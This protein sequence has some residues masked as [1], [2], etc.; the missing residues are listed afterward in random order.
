MLARELVFP[1]PPDVG[2][3]ARLG[4][5]GHRVVTPFVVQDGHVM[6]PEA[7]D[8]SPRL[9]WLIQQPR[10]VGRTSDGETVYT[11]T[12][13]ATVDS[14][15]VATAE[16][17]STE[18]AGADSG[19]LGN[20]FMTP[21]EMTPAAVARTSNSARKT[22]ARSRPPAE[23]ED[24][25][26][27]L[28]TLEHGLALD[29]AAKLAKMKSGKTL[30][31]QRA[32]FE[33][34]L[35][36]ARDQVRAALRA[37]RAAAA[38]KEQSR[39]RV[40]ELKREIAERG[41]MTDPEIRAIVNDATKKPKDKLP[42]LRDKLMAKVLKAE[43]QAAHPDNE[44]VDGVKIYEKLAETSIA[45]WKN[46]HPGQKTDGLTERDDGLYMQ[47]GEI[48][49]MVIER[50][51][52]GVRSKI[53]AREEIKTGIVDTDA[54]ARGQ[55]DAQGT[56]FTRGASGETTVRLELRGRDISNEIDLASDASASKST[57]GPAGKAFDNSLG[58]TATDLEG[59]CRD[60][61]SNVA[62]HEDSP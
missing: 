42:T 1:S 58:V 45:E 18:P 27:W 28:A 22:P 40:D 49:M 53:V 3:M 35:E 41:L 14:E 43:A 9:E 25:A 62:P 56:L 47:R 48:D 4:V 20:H 55:L 38:L 32:M 52:G 39:Q 8:A 33:G 2:L 31:E 29:E 46:N 10:E 19:E 36:A 30:T 61:L 12:L 24:P 37:E 34:D 16:V 13:V 15:V 57:R 51:P 23:P 60:L 6:K 50:R 21:P 11:A 17:W 5:D 7:G 59:L 44:V 54:K 26:T